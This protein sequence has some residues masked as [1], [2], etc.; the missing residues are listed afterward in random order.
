MYQNLVPLSLGF[1]SLN[2]Y[3]VQQDN[4]VLGQEL[5]SQFRTQNFTEQSELFEQLIILNN[6]DADNA[7]SKS[8]SENQLVSKSQLVNISLYLII[9]LH[10]VPFF[11]VMMQVTPDWL[12]YT[13]F[14]FASN[15]FYLTKCKFDKQD[16][17]IRN[18]IVHAL[19]V[20]IFALNEKIRKEL[21][22]VSLTNSRTKK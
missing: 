11:L 10:N 14:T 9:L 6:F 2:L 8:L 3:S 12:E 17:I 16:F 18:I 5:V 13:G 22:V 4:Y 21:F 15:I 20:L 19:L 1:Q 7:F